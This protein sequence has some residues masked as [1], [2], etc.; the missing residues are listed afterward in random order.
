MLKDKELERLFQRCK[1]RQD[2]NWQQVDW[3]THQGN[4]IDIT[5]PQHISS[6]HEWVEQEKQCHATWLNLNSF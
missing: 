2:P 5:P 4:E 1:E 3:N 6:L